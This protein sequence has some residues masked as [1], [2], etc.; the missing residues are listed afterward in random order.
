MTVQQY[1]SLLFSHMFDRFASQ[2]HIDN[3]YNRI[4]VIRGVAE[5]YYFH[6]ITRKEHLAYAD[7]IAEGHYRDFDK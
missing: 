3:I 6:V 2:N 4:V 5:P 7:M 1:R